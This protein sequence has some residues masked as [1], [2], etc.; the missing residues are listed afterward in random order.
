MISKEVSAAELCTMS[1]EELAPK[2]S[3]KLLNAQRDYF[4]GSREI[5]SVKKMVGKS[6]KVRNT[7]ILDSIFHISILYL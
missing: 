4:M 7:P 6:R 1:E 2:S 5:T 3:R